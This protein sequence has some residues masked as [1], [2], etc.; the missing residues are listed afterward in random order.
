MKKWNNPQEWLLDA[1]KDWSK[2]ELEIALQQLVD[3]IDPD[4]IQEVF[5]NDMDIDGYFK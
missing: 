1:M 4:D 3:Y 2:R 5:Q